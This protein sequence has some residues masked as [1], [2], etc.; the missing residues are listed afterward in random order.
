MDRVYSI[1]VIDSV[2][3]S[4]YKTVLIMQG[5]SVRSTVGIDTLGLKL[6]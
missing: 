2:N 5:T 4:I 1:G 3:T 6:K